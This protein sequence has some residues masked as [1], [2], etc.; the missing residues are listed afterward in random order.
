MQGTIKA[1]QDRRQLKLYPKKKKAK[2]GI[3]KEI[4]RIQKQLAAF[5]KL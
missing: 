4:R 3:R 1:A 5:N 2:A